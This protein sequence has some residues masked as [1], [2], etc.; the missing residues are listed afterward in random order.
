VKLA[1]AKAG[2]SSEEPVSA[3]AKRELPKLAV[4]RMEL[5]L[6]EAELF[7]KLESFSE[8]FLVGAAQNHQPDLGVLKMAST[9]HLQ[10]LST[11]LSSSIEFRREPITYAEF[12]AAIKT[13]ADSLGVQFNELGSMLRTIV[14]QHRGLPTRRLL[15]TMPMPILDL[16]TLATSSLYESRKTKAELADAKRTSALVVGKTSVRLDADGVIV[17]S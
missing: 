12:D 14:G 11:L 1:A 17:V 10:A 6:H 2:P 3:V 16:L 9:K 5:D 15:F 4:R 13:T 8:N 7:H